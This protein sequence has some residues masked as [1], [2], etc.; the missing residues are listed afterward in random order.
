MGR[1]AIN[2]VL[3]A[4]PNKAGSAP[5]LRQLWRPDD[6][7]GHWGKLIDYLNA[8]QGDHIVMEI[9]HRRPRNSAFFKDLRREIGS[10]SAS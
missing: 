3:S 1:A 5:V 7:E 9:A 10:A 4:V 2:R 8:L 6:P